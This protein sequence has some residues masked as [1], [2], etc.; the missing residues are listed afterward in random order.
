MGEAS[1][2]DELEAFERMREGTEVA[3]GRLPERPRRGRRPSPVPT[4]EPFSIRLRP[5]ERSLIA[6]AAL[7]ANAPSTGAWARSILTAVAQVE[8]AAG[9]AP[10]PG[11]G[12]SVPHEEPAERGRPDGSRGSGWRCP[13]Q[14]TGR[15][16][17]GEDVEVEKASQVAE[18]RRVG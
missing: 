2:R 17:G 18:A 13:D 5:K 9:M 3:E 15:E 16:L 7:R 10:V 1:F 14:P 4:M 12:G 8:L 6:E 11:V